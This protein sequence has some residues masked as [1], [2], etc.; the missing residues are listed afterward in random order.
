MS[1]KVFNRLVKLG[2]QSPD[3]R[4]DI[5]PVLH[6]FKKTAKR[7]IELLEETLGNRRYR[8]FEHPR[9]ANQAAHE[10]KNGRIIVLDNYYVVTS[11]FNAKKA[12]DAGLEVK[13][14]I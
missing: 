12:M 3:L 11:L 2:N 1:K 5:S 4:E 6:H 14:R 9:E 13:K 8:R 10:M 7:E